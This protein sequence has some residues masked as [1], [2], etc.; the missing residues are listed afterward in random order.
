MSR[1]SSGL[2][3]LPGPMDVLLR[4]LALVAC[5]LGLSVGVAACGG[6]DELGVEEPASE[7][8]AL[9]LDGIDYNVFI[10][11]QLNPAIPPDDTYYT[12]SQPAPDE[13]LYGVFIQA[14][15]NSNERRRTTDAFTVVDSQ[16]NEFEPDQADAGSIIAYE[17]RDLG[18]EECIPPAGS[19]AQLGPEG[20]SM[21]L[22]KLPLKMTENRPLELEIHG[23]GEEKLTYKLDL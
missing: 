18:P 23:Q 4:R 12:G 11:R 17:P 9:G 7:G 1:V 8:L 20:A 13:T 14:C 15:N 16:G 6:D 5:V 10:T 21:L 22:F 2:T 19:L 3:R